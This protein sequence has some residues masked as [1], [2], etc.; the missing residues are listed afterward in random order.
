MPPRKGGNLTNAPT[1]TEPSAANRDRA[2][3]LDAVLEE[4]RTTGTQPTDGRWLE[5]LTVR[6]A[7]LVSEW[8]VSDCWSW[9]D[10]PYRESTLPDA[11]TSD[12]GIDAVARRRADGRWIAIQ[13]KSRQLD[14]D[15]SGA[16]VNAGELDKF[17]A[18]AT[19]REVWAERWLVVNGAVSL[20]GYSPAKAAMS[21]SPV[22]VVNIAQA[23]ESQRAVFAESAETEPCPHCEPN[24]S[25]D[26][27][28]APPPSV[29]DSLVHAA[30]GR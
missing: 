4:L 28:K 1:G 22:K 2:N 10:W 15:G 30:G 7:P 5:D 18:A 19:D 24:S 6:V 16:P 12:V 29:A 20:G 17:L 23:V 9:A 8:D 25:A 21:G 13:V 11:P 26:A 3:A 14:F 27:G